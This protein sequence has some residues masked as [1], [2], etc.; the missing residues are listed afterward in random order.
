MRRGIDRMIRFYQRAVSPYLGHWCRFEPTC[1]EYT[2]RALRR[3]GLWM[4]L[5][6]GA[7]RILRCHPFSRGGW[8]PVPPAHGGDE[9]TDQ[10]SPA[11][12]A[13]ASRENARR[14]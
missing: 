7:W 11:R 8:D 4:G 6:M 10:D 13:P 5:W 9:R 12:E 1:S 14:R 2:R 3:H